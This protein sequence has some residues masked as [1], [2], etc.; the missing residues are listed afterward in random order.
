VEGSSC[1]E[2]FMFSDT[3]KASGT[4]IG[5]KHELFLISFLHIA[6]EVQS[7]PCFRLLLLSICEFR[8]LSSIILC[9]VQNLAARSFCKLIRL[10]QI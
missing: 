8:C 1:I 7:L 2:L 9:N 4:Q 10:V 6:F 5:H 3:D